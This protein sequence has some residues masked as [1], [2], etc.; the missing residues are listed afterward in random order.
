MKEEI[1][2]KV[3]LKNPDEVERKLFSIAKLVK[4][5]EQK[6]IYFTPKHEN[7]FDVKPPIEYLRVRIEDGKTEL[8]YKYLHLDENKDMLKNDEYEVSVGDANT[9]LEILRKLDM[10]EKVS[11]T[12]HRKSFEHGDFEISIDFIEEMGYFIEIESRKII[13]SIEETRDKCYTVLEELGVV[14]EKISAEERGYPLM[15]L[16]KNH[17]L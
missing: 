10:I 12:K 11:V 14:W 15:V 16:G 9:M 17:G 4:N 3:I 2:I 5:E 1:E 7:F 13:G 8:H 6:D